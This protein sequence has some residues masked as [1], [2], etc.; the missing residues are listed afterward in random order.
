MSTKR[1]GTHGHLGVS[2][3]VCFNIRRCSLRLCVCVCFCLFCGFPL[4]SLVRVAL[5][6]AATDPTTG[7]VDISLLTTG[8]STS[9]RQV[10]VAIADEVAEVIKHMKEPAITTKNLLARMQAR[11]Q[12]VGSFAFAFFGLFVCYGRISSQGLILWL[13]FLLL[14]LLFVSF[15]TLQSN[16]QVNL[17]MEL[18]E[19]AISIL[20]QG[21]LVM[22]DQSVGKVRRL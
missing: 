2:C 19:A 7:L 12:D 17:N 18:L 21:G 10:I 4:D 6:Q 20:H 3:T 5:Q 11:M 8:Q 22:F 14:L 9:A 13:H 16:Q 1:F 15:V